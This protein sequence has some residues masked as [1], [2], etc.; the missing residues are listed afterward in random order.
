MVTM[1]PIVRAAGSSSTSPHMRPHRISPAA[2][3]YPPSPLPRI[4]SSTS[5]TFTHKTRRRH[6]SPRATSLQNNQEQTDTTA[7]AAAATAAAEAVLRSSTVPTRR[8]SSQE[9]IDAFYASQHTAQRATYASFYSSELGGIITDP[10]LMV[11]HADDH[12]VHRG[13]AVFDTAILVKGHVYQLQQHVER[14][15]GSAAKANIPLPPRTPPDQLLRIIL[16]TT[17]ASKL[18][19]GYIRFYL[20]VGRGGFGLSP[21]ECIHSS[22]YVVVVNVDPNAAADSM[23]HLQGWKVKTSPVPSK[24]P[25]FATLKSTNYLANALALDDALAEGYNQAIFVDPGTGHVCEGPAANVGV[26]LHDGTLVVPPFDTNLP[27]VTMRRVLD[28]GEAAM[29]TGEL[30]GVGRIER[31]HVHVEEA[32][33]AAEVFMVGSSVPVMSVVGWDGEQIGDGL[34]GMVALQLRALVQGDVLGVGRGQHVE[35]PYGYLTGM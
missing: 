14:F 15:L 20:S 2:H 24:H 29:V 10:A 13:H 11:I 30:E 8:L 22:L 19:D 34:P 16:E 9:A 6:Q 23:D 21:T 32:K 3:A 27:G 17:A 5:Y 33:G 35:V 4:G 31:R 1:M 26:L 18:T 28:L 12:M 25:F 7:A